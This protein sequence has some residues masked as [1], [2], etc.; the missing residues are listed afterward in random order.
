MYVQRNFYAM[1]F[2]LYAG[3][4]PG[5]GFVDGVGVFLPFFLINGFVSGLGDG[6]I[7]GVE[8]FLAFF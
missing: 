8:V 7:A 4:G 6:F 5:D 1:P 3:P 2:F